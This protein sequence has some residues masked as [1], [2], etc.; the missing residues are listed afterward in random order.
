MPVIRVSCQTK[1]IDVD[2]DKVYDC[3]LSLYAR[4]LHRGRILLST[5]A[6]LVAVN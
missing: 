2:V 1:T 4:I 3:S 5:I 6:L